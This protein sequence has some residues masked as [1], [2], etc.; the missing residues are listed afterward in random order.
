MTGYAPDV[1]ATID[2]PLLQPRASP[3][4]EFPDESRGFL[5][6]DKSFQDIATVHETT[7]GED[8][9]VAVIDAGIPESHPDFQDCLNTEL[10]RD[11][12]G[13]GTHEPQGAQYHGTHVGGIIAADDNGSGV[14]GTASDTDLVDLRV[15]PELGAGASFGDILAA[16]VYGAAVDADVAN[17]SLG[18]YPIPRQELGSFYGKVLNSVMTYANKEG[19]LL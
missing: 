4:S 3:T 6:W 9:R 10:S 1:K 2:E 19:T 16:V 5:Q 11:F 18:A 17:L 12:T 13:T 14:V 8:T 7:K 15:F